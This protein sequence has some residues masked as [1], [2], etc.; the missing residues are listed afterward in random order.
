MIPK[1]QLTTD[2]DR[3][4]ILGGNRRVCKSYVGSLKRSITNNDM[5]MYTPIIVDMAYRIIDGQHRFTACKELGKPIYYVVMEGKESVDAMIRLNQN[6]R[7]WRMEEFL[8]YQAESKG[9]CYMELRTFIEDSKMGIS[10]AMV[11]FPDVQI[12]SSDI[13]KGEKLFN[14][15]PKADAIVDFLNSEEIKMLK[16]SKSRQFVLAVRKAFELYNDRQLNKIR[17]KAIFIQH[18]A[19]YEQYLTAFSNLIKK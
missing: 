16:F 9:G 14:K 12:N 7:M 6:Q 10:N 5:T 18:S 1:I 13:R 19:D 2:Y 3:F 8:N 11:V 15:N 4:Q 17:K